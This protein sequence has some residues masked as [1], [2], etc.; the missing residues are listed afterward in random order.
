MRR[1]VA[2]YNRPIQ[3]GM[4][5]DHEESSAQ[6]YAE[7]IDDLKQLRRYKLATV[8]NKRFEEQSLQ[9]RL[10]KTKSQ[11]SDILREGFLGFLPKETLLKDI[12][13]QGEGNLFSDK[14]SNDPLWKHMFDFFSQRQK[15][16]IVAIFEAIAEFAPKLEDETQNVKRRTSLKHNHLITLS[17]LRQVPLL[18]WLSINNLGKS[19]ANLIYEAAKKI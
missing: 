15:K 3:L 4:A 16:N 10:T 18:G 6:T 9:E 8:I 14:I 5:Q 11:T 2:N 19:R 13:P 17:D 1:E 7:H 12:Y